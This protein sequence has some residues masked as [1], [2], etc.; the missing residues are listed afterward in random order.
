MIIH[1]RLVILVLVFLLVGLTIGF[2]VGAS[3][4]LNLCIDKGTQF[5]LEHGVEVTID[6]DMLINYF[7]K[8]S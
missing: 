2:I 8:Y 4:T 6:K 7:L 5:L 3:L 1:A